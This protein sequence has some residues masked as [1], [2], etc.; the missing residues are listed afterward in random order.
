MS[1]IANNLI[2]NAIKYNVPEGS[3]MVQLAIDGE[4]VVLAVEDTGIG[5]PA[6]DRERIFERFYRVDKARSREA[7]GTGL[8]L[9]IVHD[10]VL[11]AGGSIRLEENSGSGSRFLVTLPLVS[12]DTP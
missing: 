4:D 1:H 2:E 8:G 12:E 5:I 3:V 11:H 9:S 10:I 7:G 6:E